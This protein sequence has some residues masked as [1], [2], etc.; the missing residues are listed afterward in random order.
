MNLEI[1]SILLA[2][3]FLL[4]LDILIVLRTLSNKSELA[5]SEERRQR[6]LAELAHLFEIDASW[7]KKKVRRLFDNYLRLKQSINLPEHERHKLLNLAK[8]ERI[9]PGLERRMRYRSRYQRMEAALGLALIGG[10][11]S[12][13][14]LERALA[15]EKDFPVKLFIANALADI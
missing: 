14:A 7:D 13:A 2:V 9:E 1:E 6:E 8:A 4:W 15:T 11:K 10:E 3:I 12:R 5:L